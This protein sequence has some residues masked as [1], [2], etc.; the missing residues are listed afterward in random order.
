M[1]KLFFALAFLFAGIAMNGF[2]GIEID[3]SEVSTNGFGPRKPKQVKCYYRD[4]KQVFAYGSICESGG[5]SWCKE[6]P[7]PNGSNYTVIK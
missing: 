3:D 5:T 1:K 4:P 2:T 6:N 7:C